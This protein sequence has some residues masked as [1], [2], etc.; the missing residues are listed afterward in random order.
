MSSIGL[1]EVVVVMTV[2]LLILG[3]D[4]LFVAIRYVGLLVRKLKMIYGQVTDEFDHQLRLDEML[5]NDQAIKPKSTRTT[6]SKSKTSKAI[7]NT[8]SA[9]NGLSRKSRQ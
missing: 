2:A 7:K 3:P 4:K 5:K 6:K 1:F 9:E 8:K